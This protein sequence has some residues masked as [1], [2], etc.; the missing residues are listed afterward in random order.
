MRRILCTQEKNNIRH[1]C[2]RRANPKDICR[3]KRG[4]SL[5]H[6]APTVLVQSGFDE[7]VIDFGTQLILAKP[8]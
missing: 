7:I 1:R 6:L 2:Y 4:E 5:E 8:D 3:N